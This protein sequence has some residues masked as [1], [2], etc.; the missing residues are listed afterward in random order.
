MSKTAY[1][2]FNVFQ[3]ATD[4]TFPT[5]KSGDVYRNTSTGALRIY[6]SGAWTDLPYPITVSGIAPSSPAQ[7]AVWVDTSSPGFDVT[8]YQLSGRNSVH[9]GAMRVSQRGTTGAGSTNATTGMNGMDRWMAY[10]NGF[11]AGLT[12]TQIAASLPVGFGNSLRVQRDNANAATGALHVCQTYENEGSA[13]YQS[14]PVVLSFW[15]KCGANFS[16]ASSFLTAT[17]VSGTGTEVTAVTTAGPAFVTGNVAEISTNVIL[18]TSWQRFVISDAGLA[19]GL[20]QVAIDF[21]YVPVGT[22]STNDWFEVTGVQLEEGLVV[23][24]FESRPYALELI[25]CQRSY[26]R[27]IVDG[28]AQKWLGAGQWT[29][30]TGAAASISFPV[31]MRAKPTM[32]VSGVTSFLATGPSG[33]GIASTAMTQSASSHEALSVVTATVA[34]GGTAGNACFLATN[35]TNGTWIDF[36]AEI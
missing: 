9:N 14:K 10:R 33:S 24:P 17:L 12:W 22:A 27:I 36:S 8:A 35:A 34:S 11:V 25:L 1:D 6:L 13:R 19:S 29:A 7:G 30:T 31:K 5:P 32:A 21:G 20:T 23:T 2:P 28:S 3:A 15:A 18:T 4:P 16:A 26:W